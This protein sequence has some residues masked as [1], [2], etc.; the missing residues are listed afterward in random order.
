MQQKINFQK[1]EKFIHRYSHEK[2]YPKVGNLYLVQN[3]YDCQDIQTDITK[4]LAIF[5][6]KYFWSVFNVK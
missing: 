6:Q 2:G 1:M 4:N 5:L 3:Y